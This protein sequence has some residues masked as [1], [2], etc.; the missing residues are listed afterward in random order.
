M[1]IICSIC[2]FSSAEAEAVSAAAA[3]AEEATALY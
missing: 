1:F 2:H 3:R